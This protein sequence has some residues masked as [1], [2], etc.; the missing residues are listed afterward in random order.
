MF[1]SHVYTLYKTGIHHHG[2]E[3]WHLSY[4]SSRL[5]RVMFPGARRIYDEG[6]QLISRWM[7]III[8]CGVFAWKWW[9]VVGTL[10]GGWF[11]RNYSDLLVICIYIYVICLFVV[12][13]IL[14]WSENLQNSW[15][16]NMTWERCHPNLWYKPLKGLLSWLTPRYIYIIHM[17]CICYHIDYIYICIMYIL[18]H[19]FS[20]PK[21]EVSLLSY[22]IYVFYLFKSWTSQ[23]T[24]RSCVFPWSLKEIV[25]FFFCTPK[26]L[27]HG[28]DLNFR[29]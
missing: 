23:S 24:R 13:I 17:L 28:W 14:G 19:T 8:R 3:T 22:Q 20:L 6:T 7:M 4:R 16:M 15:F 2:G 29:I 21:P 12:S 5:S 1:F 25:T 10:F 9:D 26:N 11:Y 27:Q 18:I